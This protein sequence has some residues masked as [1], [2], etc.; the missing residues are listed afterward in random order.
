MK[1]K[2]WE[3]IGKN[4]KMD[5]KSKKKFQKNSKLFQFHRKIQ[6]P[7]KKSVDLSAIWLTAKT[8]HLE[9]ILVQNAQ[10]SA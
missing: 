8:S 4:K 2:K 3:K 10:N 1:S 9:R 5:Q 7:S 6:M